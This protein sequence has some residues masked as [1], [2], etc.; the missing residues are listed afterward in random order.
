MAGV[1]YL[2]GEAGPEL[3]IPGQSGMINPN[4]GGENIY[5]TQNVYDA[6]PTRAF[7]YTDGALAALQ[8]ERQRGRS[9]VTSSYYEGGR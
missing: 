5:L 1:P 6:D 9:R 2:V 4:T 8:E 7:Q 3:F